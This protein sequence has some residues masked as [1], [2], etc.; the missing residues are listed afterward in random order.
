MAES[1][2]G[3]PFILIPARFSEIATALRYRA[4]VTAAKLAKAV[5][6]AGG[7]PLTID[8]EAPRASTPAELDNE[9]RDRIQGCRRDPPAR[10]QRTGGALG[11]PGAP[12]H[13]VRR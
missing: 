3:R 12:W 10:R 4:E 5:Y 6:A 2:G 8:P 1:S 11:R 7:K 9:V 13:P